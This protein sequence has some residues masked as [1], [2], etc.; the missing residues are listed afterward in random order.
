MFPQCGTLYIDNITTTKE[1]RR[2]T[3]MEDR[4]MI[5]NTYRKYD[6]GF[7]CEYDIIALKDLR[8]KIRE[9]YILS[10]C[11]LEDIN[12]HLEHDLL[13]RSCINWIFEK[14]AKETNTENDIRGCFLAL[15]TE[16]TEWTKERNKEYKRIVYRKATFSKEIQDMVCN[17]CDKY[18]EKI[19]KIK[20]YLDKKIEEEKERVEREKAEWK[21]LKIYDF[22]KPS[23]GEDGVDGYIDAEYLRVKDNTVIR[24][25]G[26]DIF[27]F[28]RF[29]FP[30]RLE[31]AES[32]FNGWTEDEKQLIGWLRKYGVFRS[33]IRM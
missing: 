26:A 24:I 19:S 20:E 1:E 2:S 3:N 11:G 8:K 14:K 6:I 30:K 27:D 28:G 15:S 10:Y 9:S 13:E 21:E 29:Y 17:K 5:F 4:L 23:G 16:D 22:V 12:L 18:I 7:E 32:V 25:I 31:D 33:G